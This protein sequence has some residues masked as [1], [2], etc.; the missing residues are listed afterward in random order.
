MKPNSVR[1]TPSRKY[2]DRYE[3]TASTMQQAFLL[4]SGYHLDHTSEP[5]P[6][7]PIVYIVRIVRYQSKQVP[8]KPT[9]S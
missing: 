5:E 7:E 2:Y 4:P 8:T 9:S 3:E 6:S 1:R